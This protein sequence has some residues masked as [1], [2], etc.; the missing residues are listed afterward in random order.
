M[1]IDFK[2][3]NG[4]IPAIIQDK[5]TEK[6]LMLGYMNEQALEKT[7][8]SKKVTFYSRSRQKLWTKGETSGNF[9]LVDEI[10]FDCDHDALLIKAKP[11]GPVCHTGKDTCF[12]EINKGAGNFLTELELII[13]DR[14]KNMPSGSYTTRLFT[15]GLNKIAQKVGEEATEAIIEAIGGNNQQMKEEVADLF[16]HL[17]VLLVERGISL[18]EIEEVLARRHQ[19]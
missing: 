11:T 7:R 6:V 14:K 10:H 12:S 18:R 3:N 17:L 13:L 9:L 19:K 2:K 1:K 8:S 5:I 4:L 15:K 16:Y